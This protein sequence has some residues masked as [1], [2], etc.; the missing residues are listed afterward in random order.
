MSD[1]H[2]RVTAGGSPI[3]PGSPIVGL[4]FGYEEQS[5]ISIISAQE[6]EYSYSPK[7]GTS[8]GGGTEEEQKNFKENVQTKI[9]LHKMVFPTQK[10]L[11]WYRVTNNSSGPTP[12]DLFISNGPI[13][14]L[15]E[16]PV[17][18]LMNA[19]A[20]STDTVDST[21]P[22]PEEE[23]E[24]ELPISTFETVVNNI[25]EA[26]FV[27]LEFELETFEPE[28]IA[29]E[30]VFKTQPASSHGGENS[31]ALDLQLQGLRSSIQSMDARVAVLLDFLHKTRDGLIPPNYKLLREV[32]SVIKQ[33]PVIAPVSELNVEFDKNYNETLILSYLAVVA[34]TTKA[35]ESHS[36]K[37]KALH[38]SSSREM[39]R[40]Y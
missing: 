29:V 6:I 4:L 19:G 20:H 38:E 37:F 18:L 2:T 8:F 28:R 7:K 9:E 17:F 15:S 34:K 39:R 40:G 21:K 25:G 1:H 12:N 27:N 32:D 36:E 35:I 24:A 31:S 33:L 13:Q 30:K 10:V 14:E 5:T 26:V 11:G 22:T 23:E 3:A 16:S